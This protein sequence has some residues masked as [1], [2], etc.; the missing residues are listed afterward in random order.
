MTNVFKDKSYGFSTSNCV[1][2]DS[3]PKP[4]FFLMRLDIASVE[5]FLIAH[6]LRSERHL[7]RLYYR[8]YGSFSNGSKSEFFPVNVFKLRIEM[9][10]FDIL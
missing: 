9:R 4:I 1:G 8:S 7:Y 10:K 3:G 2:R 6:H 5:D